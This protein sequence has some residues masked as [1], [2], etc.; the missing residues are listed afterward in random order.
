MIR[1]KLTKPATKKGITLKCPSCGSELFRVVAIEQKQGKD[2]CGLCDC[3][4]EWQI[5]KTI[6]TKSDK[7]EG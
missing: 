4:F 1:T 3:E 2:F 6:E 5:I 7:G